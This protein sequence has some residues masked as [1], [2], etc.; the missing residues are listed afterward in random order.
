MEEPGGGSAALPPDD[1][2]KGGEN[3]ATAVFWSPSQGVYFSYK[4]QC[5][6]SLCKTLRNWPLAESSL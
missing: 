2:K 6:C 4:Y 3:A 5:V 1:L